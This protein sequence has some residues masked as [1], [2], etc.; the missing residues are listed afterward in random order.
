MPSGKPAGVR[1]IQ[2]DRDNRCRLF[3]HPTR[4]AVC[5][6]LQPDPEMCR[7]DAAQAMLWL[8]K[9]DQQ[10]APLPNPTSVPRP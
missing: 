1:C 10:T 2:L 5:H 7:T 9:V 8:A 3:G 6:S 4:P